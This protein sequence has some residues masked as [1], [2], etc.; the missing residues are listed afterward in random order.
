MECILERFHDDVLRDLGRPIKT[1]P[2]CVLFKVEICRNF[3]SLISVSVLLVLV[4]K[5]VLLVCI[6][7]QIMCDTIKFDFNI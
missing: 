2:N 7:S 1:R 4:W 5:D 3:F 6:L